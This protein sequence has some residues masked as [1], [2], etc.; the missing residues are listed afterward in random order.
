[1]VKPK[2]DQAEQRPQRVKNVKKSYNVS[3]TSKTI[4]KEAKNMK[5]YAPKVDK[6]TS[7]KRIPKELDKKKKK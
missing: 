2:D 4:L 7:F 5:Y 6:K 1:M 3:P